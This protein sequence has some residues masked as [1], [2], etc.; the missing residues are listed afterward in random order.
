MMN[1]SRELER[2]CVA[3]TLKV[4]LKASDFAFYWPLDLR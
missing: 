1:V 4:K 2:A 3:F